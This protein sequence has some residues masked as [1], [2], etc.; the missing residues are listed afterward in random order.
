[1]IYCEAV[2]SFELYE[3]FF[4]HAYIASGHIKYTFEFY[5]TWENSLL[6]NQI[7]RTTIK[8]VINCAIGNLFYH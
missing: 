6:S 5:I 8:S 4:A 1:M 3:S 2:G 7:L